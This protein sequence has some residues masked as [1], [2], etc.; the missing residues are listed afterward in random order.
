[1]NKFLELITV[2]MAAGGQS[3]FEL[4]GDYFEIIESQYPITVLLEDRNGA[5]IGRMGSAEASY[6]LRDTPFNA[7]TIASA[8]AQ[9]V[10]IAFGSGEAG[11]RR[12]AGFVQ[13][14]DGGKA[15]TLAGTAFGWASGC[16]ATAATYASAQLWNPAGSTKRL[17]VKTIKASVN[18]PSI[19]AVHT[20]TTQLASA[21]SAIVNSKLP[22][23]PAPVATMRFENLAAPTASPVYVD[24]VPFSAAGQSLITLQE[25]VIL[26]PG[27]GLNL[28]QGNVNAQ[29]NCTFE[30]FE[31]TI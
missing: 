24:Y 4:A 3:R 10:R 9:T 20:R 22:G 26:V 15:R 30:W 23:G 11:T 7:I 2:P 8:Q 31:E 25:P 1:M 13:V 6:F 18:T 14:V 12:T 16:G 27:S 19:V 21:A 17:I 29:V 28:E 5:Q